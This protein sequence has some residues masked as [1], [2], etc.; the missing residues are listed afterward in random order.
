MLATGGK[1]TC[2]PDALYNLLPH[3]S[4]SVDLEMLRT[5]MPAD[6]HAN[7][8][9]S[10]AD[11]YLGQFGLTLPRVT[12]RFMVAGGVELALLKAPGYYV[13]QLA[14]TFDNCDKKPDLHCVACDGETVRDNSRHAKVKVLD[15]SDR[16]SPDNARDV[17]RSL[18]PG[19]KVVV[20]NVYELKRKPGEENE[21]PQAP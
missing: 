16:S 5:M 20:K 13:A 11:A 17:F 12:K 6:P 4:V 21:D 3:L 2:L 7:T 14:V 8:L 9:F 10:Q 1:R 18:F 15:A 19:L